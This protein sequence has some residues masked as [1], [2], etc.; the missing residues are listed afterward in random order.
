MTALLFDLWLLEDEHPHPHPAPHTPTAVHAGLA[1]ERPPEF[2]P[3]TWCVLSSHRVV[4]PHGPE[5][6]GAG[7][8]RAPPL[9]CLSPER[10]LASCAHLAF[11][12]F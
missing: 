4:T 6:C 2:L 5:L 8:V 3:G 12:C 1:W 11:S 7:A 10:G 9:P